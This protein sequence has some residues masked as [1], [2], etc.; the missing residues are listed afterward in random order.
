MTEQLTSKLKKSE[1]LIMHTPRSLDLEI[2]SQCNLRCRYCYYF[3]NPDV[4]YH[5]LPTDEWMNFFDEC[6]RCAIMNVTLQGGEPFMRKDLPILIDG[7][8]RNRM[9]F[10]I[11][12]NGMLIDDNI[13]SFIASTKRCNSIQ[14][15]VD[16]SRPEIHDA[17]RGEGSFVGA[18]RGIQTLKR[19]KIPVTV[20]VT[21]N[22]QNVY[23][24]DSLYQF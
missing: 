9:R 12:S 7:I 11:L 23:D 8:I 19:Y 14:I 5:D 17:C 21:I 6:G 18:I 4:D 16:G 13:A 24:L 20:R 22:R 1:L 15:S 3:N 2:T 10:S